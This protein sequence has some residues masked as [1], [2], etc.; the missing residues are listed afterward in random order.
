MDKVLINI[1][2]QVSAGVNTLFQTAQ[3]LLSTVMQVAQHLYLIL[4]RQ[5]VILG[6][7]EFLQGILWYVGAFIV[8]RFHKAVWKKEGLAEWDKYAV[9]LF[10]II[11][12][13]I[14]TVKGTE[15]V[16][17]SLPRLFNPE[18]YAIQEGVQI[19]HQIK[20]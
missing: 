17:A 4:V 16:L 2:N 8:Y 7:Q 9:G 11:I 5:Q 10:F 14:L 15:H 20:Q 12:V 13:L 1:T 19:L 3:Q 18:Y 6:V